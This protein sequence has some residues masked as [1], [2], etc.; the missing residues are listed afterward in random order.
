MKMMNNDRKSFGGGWT[1]IAFVAAVL[2]YPLS[3]PPA[4][5]IC[6]ELTH[7]DPRLEMVNTVY[8]PLVWLMAES[9][10]LAHAMEWYYSVWL[11]IAKH[12][13]TARR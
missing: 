9:P 11:D 6:A 5:W 4:C 12:V 7:P 2:V 3:F 10:P 13:D 8:S 1:L